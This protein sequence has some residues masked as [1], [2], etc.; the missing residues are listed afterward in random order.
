MAGYWPQSRSQIHDQN[1]K[2]YIRA[3]ATFYQGG[4]TTP[5]T[6][7]R[8]SG[9]AVPH[10]NPLESDGFGLFPGVFLDEA[11]DFYRVR[12]TT[13]GG[14][15]LY[16]DDGIPII[17]PSAGGGGPPPT[18]VDPDAVYKTG[19][20]MF[21]YIA[22]LRP[23]FVRLNGRSVGSAT[24]G[25]SE[26]ANSDTQ[27]LY[28]YLWN[29]D[30]NIVITGGRGASAPADFAANKPLVLP[31]W[32]GR[33]A[34]GLDTMGNTAANVL[35]E[36]NVVGWVGGLRNHVLTSAQM[37]SHAHGIT[38]PG[39]AHALGYDVPLRRPDT[40]R[41]NPGASSIFSIDEFHANASIIAN[42]TGITVN[43][44][45]GGEA[46]NNVQPSAAGAWYM[47]L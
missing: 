47:R 17:G 37:P 12:V 46:H 3:R 23:G 2:P 16:D 8:D 26:R 4:T 42:F 34:V 9:L 20:I 29:G 21:R 35:P 24:S 38:D 6:V 22:E 33:G 30:P 41:G 10:P 32:R 11:D 31:D 5:I 15:L 7:Y 44:T 13:S 19:D 18:P 40:D 43:P 25:A 45:G 27:P 39:H 1:G 14:V 36:A 28:E